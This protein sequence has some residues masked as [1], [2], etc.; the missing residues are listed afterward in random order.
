M[1]L[2]LAA[3]SAAG[4]TARDQWKEYFYC[5]ALP[6]DVIAVQ[7]HK[8]TSGFSSNAGNDNVITN[9]SMIVVADGQCMVI[10]EQGQVVEI[11]AEPGEFKYDNT[12]APSIFTGNLGDSIKQ[13]FAEPELL[14]KPIGEASG[15]E[16]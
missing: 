10:V 1:G 16:Y 6:A 15:F 2:I 12:I 4:S 8:K 13:V 11:C 9:G 7:G 5:D 3:L 14:E